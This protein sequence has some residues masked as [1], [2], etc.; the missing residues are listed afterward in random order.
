ME[1]TLSDGIRRRRRRHV[2]KI[3]VRK[4]N[5]EIVEPEMDPME[6]TASVKTMIEE[7]GIHPRF[8]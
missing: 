2:R 7:E 6:T 4:L 3:S 1:T 5:G 8:L